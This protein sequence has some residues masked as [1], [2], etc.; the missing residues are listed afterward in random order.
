MS[1]V[2]LHTGAARWDFLKIRNLDR[3]RLVWTLRSTRKAYDT[4]DAVL[5]ARIKGRRTAKGTRFHCQSP[6]HEFVTYAGAGEFLMSVQLALC[7]SER[8]CVSQ[9][10]LFEHELTLICAAHCEPPAFAHADMHCPLQHVFM[11]AHHAVIASL[12]AGVPVGHTHESTP[13]STVDESRLSSRASSP[14]PSPV[15]SLP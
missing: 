11:R 3:T 1:R 7:R 12:Q 15:V 9:S 13:V 10:I 4:F 14:P 2:P 6:Q 5:R 8:H